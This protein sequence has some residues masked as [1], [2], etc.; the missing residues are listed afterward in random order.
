MPVSI[1][2]FHIL[3]GPSCKETMEDNSLEPI[4]GL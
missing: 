2:T 1:C 4:F 3:S